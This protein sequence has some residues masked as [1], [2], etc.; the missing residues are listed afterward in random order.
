MKVKKINFSKK[1]AIGEG[2]LNIYRLF[3]VAVIAIIVLGFS[4]VFYNYYIN[5]KDV[6]AQVLVGD[7][8]DCL[9]PQG[10]YV[11]SDLPADNKEILKYCGFEDNL[12]RVYVNATIFDSSGAR[13]TNFLQGESS[14]LWIREIFEGD[15]AENIKKYE[16]GYVLVSYP[17]SI[18]SGSGIEIGEINIE[19]L[20][21]YED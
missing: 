21:K 14:D 12:G 20:V 5:I 10:I 18:D 8:I 13:V 9:A 4:A 17:A 1:A 16:P 2:I 7:V 15:K 19:V 6:E 11:L 3:L